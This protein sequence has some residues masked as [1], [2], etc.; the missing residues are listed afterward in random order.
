MEFKHLTDLSRKGLCDW[1][2]AD[3]ED[4]H[5]LYV[6]IDWESRAVYVLDNKYTESLEVKKE[7]ES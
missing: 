5:W 1:Y 3:D 7:D 2:M 6:Q 4:G